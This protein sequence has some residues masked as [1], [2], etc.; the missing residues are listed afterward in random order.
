MC[1][2]LQTEVA[3]VSQTVHDIT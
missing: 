1:I 3:V 2:L